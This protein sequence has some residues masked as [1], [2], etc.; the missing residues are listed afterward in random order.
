MA[1]DN[2]LQLDVGNSGAKWRLLNAD[3]G[4]I[5]RG[6]YS[7]DDVASREALL[8]CSESVARIWV[9]SVASADNDAELS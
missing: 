2:C 8:N 9:A 7:P 1:G 3:G 6:R 4:V 5:D